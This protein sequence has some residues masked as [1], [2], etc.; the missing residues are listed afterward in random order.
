MG[1]YLVS[2]MP[3]VA[4]TFAQTILADSCSF[5]LFE[6]L[7]PN[8]EMSGQTEAIMGAPDISLSYDFSHSLWLDLLW[9]N[10]WR[11]NIS[12]LNPSLF[13]GQPFTSSEFLWW[14]AG[15]LE[16]HLQKTF[17]PTF[18]KHL[19]CTRYESFHV[20]YRLTDD[21][22]VFIFTPSWSTFFTGEHFFLAGDFAG[23]LLLGEFR[24]KLILREGLGGCL[25]VFRTNLSIFQR[26]KVSEIPSS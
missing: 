15:N 21:C 17:Y 24:D 16:Q 3:S 25:G 7:L 20:W 13:P 1:L 6:I 14:S 5:K 11:A 4:T 23:V 8:V 10:E 9:Y 22:S 2:D 19:Y 26:Q 12:G 18:E